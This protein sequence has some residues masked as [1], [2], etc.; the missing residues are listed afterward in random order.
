MADEPKRLFQSAPS[1]ARVG[2]T[3]Y[4]LAAS[5]FAGSTYELHDLPEK[6]T[7]TAP[8]GTSFND[9][10]GDFCASRLNNQQRKEMSRAP[11]LVRSSPAQGTGKLLDALWLRARE[12]L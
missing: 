2:D 4:E 7:H 8:S 11:L 3:R 9:E 12:K 5:P 10:N 1:A 6:A